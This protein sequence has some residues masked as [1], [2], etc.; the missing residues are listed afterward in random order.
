MGVVCVCGGVAGGEGEGWGR[1]R[2]RVIFNYYSI[3]TKP[4]RSQSP[5]KEGKGRH[6]YACQRRANRSQWNRTPR[7]QCAWE[8][9]NAAAET[10]SAREGVGWRYAEAR[11]ARE[12]ANES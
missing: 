3:I 12:T 9:G 2:V 10:A 7:C 6:V 1:A 5:N 11:Y 4:V 8:R